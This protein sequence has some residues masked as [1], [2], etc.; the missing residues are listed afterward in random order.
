MLGKNN[1]ILS[2]N[3]GKKKQKNLYWQI[4]NIDFFR[5]KLE[6]LVV[7]NFIWSKEK[8]MF[9]FTSNTLHNLAAMT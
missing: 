2:F 9:F 4:Q 8:K 6:K 3:S 1:S 7:K 5:K